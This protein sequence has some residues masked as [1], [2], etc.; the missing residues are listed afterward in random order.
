MSRAGI[1]AIV[2]TRTGHT[3][4][5]ASKNLKQ[6]RVYHWNYVRHGGHVERTMAGLCRE[7]GPESMEWRILEVVG[8]DNLDELLQAAET[9]WMFRTRREIGE[10]LVNQVSNRY[11]VRSEFGRTM[12][13]MLTEFSAFCDARELVAK[14]V[15]EELL[16]GYMKRLDVCQL[17]PAQSPPRKSPRPRGEK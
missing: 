1:Y 13:A 11:R 6:R 2:C 5:G 9:R 12:T 16:T 7:Y 3:Y 15:L 10:R 14:D 8:G 17:L 4:I